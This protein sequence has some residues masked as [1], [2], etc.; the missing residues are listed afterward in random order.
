M[1]F[2]RRQFL[3]T[4][5]AT[6]ATL[7]LATPEAMAGFDVPRKRARHKACRE[8]FFF[9]QYS[10]PQFGFIDDK[11]GTTTAEEELMDKVVN[12]I[13]QLRP[14][15]VIATG[16]Y[17]HH[18]LNENEMQLYKKYV[19]MIDPSVKVL[20]VPGNHDINSLDPKYL[21]FY[22]SNISADHFYY[23]YEGC[24][25]IGLNSTWICNPGSKQE[26]EQWQWLCEKLEEAQRCR[27]IFVVAHIPFLITEFDEDD[28][29]SNIPQ[30]QR[31]RYFVLFEQ[32]GVNAVFCGHLHKPATAQHSGIDY[33][34]CG[35]TGKQLGGFP[36]MNLIQ[37]FPDYYTVAYKALDN[38]PR[39][40]FL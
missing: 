6:T 7:A 37:V 29:Y 8:P 4:G 27:F 39:R 19:A 35:S 13:N 20:H 17:V 21:T 18:L 28:N 9:I 11:G 2:N 1:A 38:F 40:L 23:E 33:F 5:F 10:D 32:Y 26:A 16:D 30:S 36:G 3:K 25:F 14:P 22:E 31:Y 15:F 24:A 34:T 12:I